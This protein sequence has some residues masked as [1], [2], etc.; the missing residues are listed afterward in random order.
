[1]AHR[2]RESDLVFS[3]EQVG[4]VILQMSDT[5]LRQLQYEIQRVQTYR[6]TSLRAH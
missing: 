6:S 1:V 2:G 5:V 3:T 4:S